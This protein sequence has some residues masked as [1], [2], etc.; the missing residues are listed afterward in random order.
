MNDNNYT[1][2][3]LKRVQN[4]YILEKKDIIDG[5]STEVETLV[6]ADGGEGEYEAFQQ[7][8]YDILEN[9]GPSD[10]RYS[11]KR[12][13]VRIEPGDKTDASSDEIDWVYECWINEKVDNE[14]WA[15]YGERMHKQL[16][17]QLKIS[18]DFKKQNGYK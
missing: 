9:Y 17:E 16:K 10:G 18:Q 13:R 12:L 6:G 4:G 11:P 7:F 1:L 15:T 14:D 8:L 2:F 3:K 5:K